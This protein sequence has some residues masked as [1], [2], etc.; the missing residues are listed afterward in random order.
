MITHHV[1]RRPSRDAFT[2]T[3]LLVAMA[4]IIFVMSILN[5]AFTEGLETFRKMKGAGDMSEELRRRREA[6]RR[7]GG[8]RQPRV[9]VRS[10]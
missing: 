1:H 10:R 7:C 4:L 6:P 2:I 9:G 5:A 8:D 3:E